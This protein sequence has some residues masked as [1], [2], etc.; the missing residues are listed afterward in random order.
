MRL[1]TDALI[2]VAFALVVFGIAGLQLFQGALKRRC[3]HPNTGVA[4]A[5]PTFVI[6]YF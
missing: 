1:F 3:F 4:Y 2:I 5:L 6:C